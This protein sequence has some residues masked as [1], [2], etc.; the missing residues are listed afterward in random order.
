MLSQTTRGI[1]AIIQCH[2]CANHNVTIMQCFL[3]FYHTDTVTG[4]FADVDARQ[5]ISSLFRDHYATIIQHQN[6]LE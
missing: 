5:L 3:L 6:I 2:L 1:Q 4:R